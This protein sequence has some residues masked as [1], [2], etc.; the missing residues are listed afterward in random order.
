MY[1]C[2]LVALKEALLTFF[3][4]LRLIR[5]V[6]KNTST[7][8][9]TKNT[10]PLHRVQFDETVNPVAPVVCCTFFV[11]NALLPGRVFQLALL[12]EQLRAGFH[13][14]A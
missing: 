2:L 9:N 13:R 10:Y 12:V 1:F 14:G 8:P 11:S 4:I 6:K 5:G 7:I 3:P